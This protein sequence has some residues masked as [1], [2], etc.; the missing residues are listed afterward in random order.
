MVKDEYKGIDLLSYVAVRVMQQVLNLTYIGEET[1][2]QHLARWSFDIA[3]AF[4]EERE[5]RLK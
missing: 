4:L 1:K 3:E 2:T 5:R